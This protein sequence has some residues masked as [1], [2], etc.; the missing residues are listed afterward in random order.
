MRHAVR[1]VSCLAVA[2]AIQLSPAWS[3]S[4]VLNHDFEVQSDVSTFPADWFRGGS[5]SYILDDD[6]DG[7]GTDS[8]QIDANGSDWRSKAIFV[9]PGEDITWSLD[10]KFLDGVTGQFSADIRFFA[11]LDPIG[12]GT[13]GAF[14]GEQRIRVDSS[15]NG[16]WLTSG[17][18][19]ITV[20]AGALT[21]D[22]RI[23]AG[24]FD[25]GLTGGGVRLDKVLVNVPEPATIGTVL[26]GV[27]ACFARRRELR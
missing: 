24:F 7:V 15:A 14:R 3:Q 9:T 5:V 20:P 18:N 26:L 2:L 10:Y 11:G 13:A 16:A 22:I 19:M 6:S 1:F 21:A 25:S 23:S 4:L 12:G 27:A 17:P 8:V